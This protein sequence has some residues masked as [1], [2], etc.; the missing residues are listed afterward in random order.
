MKSLNKVQ[1][2]GYI[3]NDAE[4]KYTPDGKAIINFTLATSDTVTDKET[5]GKTEITTW[6]N[7]D[8][9]EKEKLAPYLLKGKRIYVEGKI[10]TRQ[11][12]DKD[13]IVRYWTSIVGHNVIFLDYKREDENGVSEET[14]DSDKKTKEL[15]YETIPQ[16]VQTEEESDIPFA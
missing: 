1:L 16:G 10:R 3:G 13:G 11:F 15:Q 6:H 7:I 14:P 4:L 5:G 8:L 12:T 9:W 2:I